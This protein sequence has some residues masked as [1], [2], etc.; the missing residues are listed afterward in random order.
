M[1]Q[2]I[3]I[4]AI[5]ATLALT[6]F[7]QSRQFKLEKR[8]FGYYPWSYRIFIVPIYEEILFRG[9]ILYG[10]IYHFSIPVAITASSLLFGLWHLKNYKIQPKSATAGQILYSGAVLGP[11]FAVLTLASGSLYPAI[12]LHALNNLLAPVGWQL[13]NKLSK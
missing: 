6:Y 4:F 5:T 12:L 11:L 7:Y 1:Q 3:Y 10:L 8:V 9:I 2:L 13:I